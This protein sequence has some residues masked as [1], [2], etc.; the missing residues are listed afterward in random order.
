M[1]ISLEN[2]SI[3]TQFEGP[4]HSNKSSSVKLRSMQ[5]DT[6]LNVLWL[7]E[8]GDGLFKFDIATEKT[9][10]YGAEAN[11]GIADLNGVY[12]ISQGQ[13]GRLWLGT[14]GGV[15]SMDPKTEIFTYYHHDPNDP[16]SLGNNLVYAIYV[17]R[18][19]IVWVGT[20]TNGVNIYD[21]GLIRFGHEQAEPE[22]ENS[23]RANGVFSIAKDPKG[24]IWFGTLNGGTSVLDPNSGQFSHYYTADTDPRIWSK[25]YMARVRPD[26]D[27]TVWFG[28]F[29][30]GLFRLDVPTGIFDHYRNIEN[31]PHSFSDKTIKDILQTQDGTIWIATETQGLERF[32]TETGSFSH[33]KHDP[34]NPQSISSN[35][36]Y[37]LL[38]DQAG[39]IWIGTADK[40]L[41]SF[42]RSTGVFTHYQVDLGNESSLS[43]NCILSLYEDSQN[44]LWIGT[45]SGG[46]NK[47]DPSRRNISTMDLELEL[48]GLTIFGILQDDLGYLWLSSN[49]G[50]LKV[51]PDSGLVNT[52]T[53]SNGLQSEFYF[54]SCVKGDDGL[55]YF[56]GGEGYNVFYPDSIKNNPHV[57]PIVLTGL[58]INYENVPLGKILADRNILSESITYSKELQLNYWDK[59]ISFQFA[60]LNFSASY[61]NQYAYKMEGYDGDWIDAGFDNSAQYMNLPAG[62]YTF[63][64]RGSNNDG[65]WNMHGASI[66]LIIAPPFWQTWWFKT[67][68]IIGLLGLI[69]TYIQL[70]ISRLIAQRKELEILVRDR[71]AQL[72]EE[73]EE[74]QRVELEKTELKL[75]HLKRELLTQSLH[76]NDK[77]QIMDNLQTELETFSKLGL[78]E[79]RPKLNKLLRSLRDRSSVKQ[80]WEEFELW[81][82]EIHTGFYINLRQAHSELSE[83]ELKVCALLRLNL[84]SKDIAKVMNVQ[85]SSI[86]IYRHRIRKKLG[87]EGDE[88]LS[89]FLSKY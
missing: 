47:L 3:K 21:P 66:A 4:F 11:R 53:E 7:G 73:I 61:K 40:G 13:D 63:H 27:R 2:N 82:T 58:A 25:N 64:V 76:L 23:I 14:V 56:G 62:A 20:E 6:T 88:N 33:Y 54:S 17:D 75:D 77:Q 55:M 30:C 79:L 80:G 32:N 19:G 87:I 49:Q 52:Y 68:L 60:A 59:V 89:T 39:G 48:S 74:R 5:A 36:G 34:Q 26:R 69:L 24:N 31:D 44:N 67:L 8:F 78:K 1:K 57:P 45:R 15:T 35:F 18:Q 22:N 28:S 16:T 10:Y 84:I 83:S 41:N 38:E 9:V 85:S 50:I 81:F 86:D 70:R 43:S 42:D 12:A 72:K 65:V 37:C 71:T 46:L 51:H 29:E